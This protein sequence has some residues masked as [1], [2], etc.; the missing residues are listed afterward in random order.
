M[1]ESTSQSKRKCIFA[2]TVLLLLFL[3]VTMVVVTVLIRSVVSTLVYLLLIILLVLLLF[4]KEVFCMALGVLFFTVYIFYV[5]SVYVIRGSPGSDSWLGVTGYSLCGLSSCSSDPYQIIYPYNANGQ[6]FDYAYDPLVWGNCPV[7]LEPDYTIM[8]NWCRWGDVNGLPIQGYEENY[9][10]LP[11]YS[12][13]CTAGV[14]CVPTTRP[15]DY[16]DPGI[17]L[18]NGFLH[19]SSINTAFCPGNNYTQGEIICSRCSDYF[20]RAGVL[21]QEV[22]CGL[23]Q[24]SDFWCWVFCPG[25]SVTGKEKFDTA[26]LKQKSI[27]LYVTIW[28]YGGYLVVILLLNVIAF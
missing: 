9:L 28:C 12:L 21:P 18:A 4:Y 23:A 2:L 17:G 26:S 19:A 16:P 15:Q 1:F 7:L 24:N 27:M 8:T 6:L 5:T 3:F 25:A 22:N 10:G 11:N 13:P 14:G 20:Y